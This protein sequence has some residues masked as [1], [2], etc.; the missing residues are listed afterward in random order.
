LILERLARGEGKV[1]GT[2]VAL[3]KQLRAAGRR[4]A[5]VSAS[6]NCKAVLEGAGITNLFDTIVDGLVAHEE[7]LRG[8][9]APDTFLFAAGSL[10]VE[11][12]FAAVVEDA[13][14]GVAS[15]RAGGFGL[16]VGV[17]RRATP[18]ELVAA[19]A[20]VVVS[21]LSELAAIVPTC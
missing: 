4:I 19:G 3:V 11:A 5:V 21:D 16:V 1:F 10:G 13:P 15:G 20:H 14:A 7:H 2:S 18:D 8:K 17:A 9:P 12:A 6:E